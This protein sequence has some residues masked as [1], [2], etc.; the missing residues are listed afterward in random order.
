MVC[1]SKERIETGIIKYQNHSECQLQMIISV[2][3]I[4]K[5]GLMKELK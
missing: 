4:A 5:S 3:G 1:P 2:G